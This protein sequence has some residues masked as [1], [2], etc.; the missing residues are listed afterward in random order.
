MPTTKPKPLSFASLIDPAK[1]QS[2]YTFSVSSPPF[3]QPGLAALLPN[4]ATQYMIEARLVGSRITCF[5]PPTNTDQDVLILSHYKRLT[6]LLKKD[7]WI[8]GGSAPT[9]ARP[10]GGSEVFESYR[11]DDINLI[12][13]PSESF[14]R[15][16]MHATELSTRFNLQNKSDRIALFQ[17]ILYGPQ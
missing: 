2:L 7:G 6:A 11:K 16:F 8:P 4:G 14:Y 17:A 3:I 1:S 12:I 13:T 10:V 15:K 5:P 9:S